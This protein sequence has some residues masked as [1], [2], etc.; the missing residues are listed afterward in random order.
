MFLV[1]S[2]VLTAQTSSAEIVSNESIDSKV[3]VNSAISL[4]K[5]LKSASVEKVEAAREVA[6]ILDDVEKQMQIPNEMRGMTLAAACSE[7]GFN[8]SA[9]GDRKFSKNGKKP[10]A[11]GVLQ[12]WPFYEKAYD[13]D[14]RDPRSSAESWLTHIKKMIPKVK[15]DCK[16][17]TTK[18]IWVAAWVTGIRYKKPGGR[19]KEKPLHLKPFLRIRKSYETQIKNSLIHTGK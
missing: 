2:I 16:Y 14:R 13:T 7:S 8:P 1:L 5:N 10:M 18:K 4:C 19:C 15:R 17:K 11:L 3:L 6:F 12:L 9:L